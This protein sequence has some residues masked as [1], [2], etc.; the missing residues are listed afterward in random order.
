MSTLYEFD[1]DATA[2]KF[3]HMQYTENSLDIEA[4]SLCTHGIAEVH[5]HCH[6]R[7]KSAFQNRQGRYQ[8]GNTE[9]LHLLLDYYQ[10]SNPRLLTPGP[11]G[12]NE[13]TAMSLV[14]STI[15]HLHFSQYLQN[16]L[17]FPTC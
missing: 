14:I 16:T 15:V 7:L 5:F 9:A 3:R 8:Q 2:I 12:R 6:V 13:F 4:C 1:R 17:G 11:T 10:I